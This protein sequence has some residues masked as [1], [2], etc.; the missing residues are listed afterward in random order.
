M[1]QDLVPAGATPPAPFIGPERRTDSSTR[2]FLFVIFK[3]RNLIIG[4]ALA[5]TGAALIA[6]LA[7]PP[8]RSAAAK[9]LIKGDRATLQISGL[10]SLTARVPHSP[11]ILQSEVELL[12]S[13][14]VLL[15]VARTLLERKAARTG[16]RFGAEDLENTIGA[17]RNN[18]LPSA[19]PDTNVIQ[20][21]YYDKTAEGAEASLK[22]IID[23][24][25]Q[26]HAMAYSGSNDL[27]TFYQREQEKAAADLQRAEEDLRRWQEANNVVAIEGQIQ[28]EI[29]HLA[30]LERN[31]HQV[32][33]DLEATRGRIANVEAQRAAQPE[34]AVMIREKVANPLIAKLKAD[35]AAAEVALKDLQ[36]NPVIEKLKGDVAAAEVAL[37]EPDKTPLV[38]KLRADVVAA[39][40]ALQELRQRYTDKDRR[41]Q[42]KLEQIAGIKKELA[43]AEKD[44]DT[45]ARERLAGLR[46][47]LA[48]AERDAETEARERISR[49]KREL[50]AAQAEAEI[51][52]RETMGPNPVREG[53]DRDL[54][55]ARAQLSAL[56]LQRDALRRQVRD[57][58]QT[59]AAL[60]DKKVAVDRLTRDVNVARD[61]YLLH[62]KRLNDSKLAAELDKQQLTDVALIERPYA[63]GE[64]DLLRRIA[65]VVLAGFVGLG[66]GA[67]AAF[68]LEFFNHSLRTSDDVEFHLGLPVL[69]VVPALPALRRAAA[70]PAWSGS[71][72]GAEQTPGSKKEA[73]S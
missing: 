3:W 59:L 32:E 51:P 50:A 55:T 73:T 60:R 8:V 1:Q 2:Q 20:I 61:T 10:Q 72:P 6:A 28:S 66:L 38:A 67:A 30:G 65:L 41:V 9:I 70:L 40:L 69:A 7:K 42:E 27:L 46:R 12:R 47:E 21:T 31:L 35:L 34:R 26:Q 24:Y 56:G 57:V 18:L 44:A 13:R 71:G 68:G 14:A 37:K 49:I 43:A 58:S 63:T 39:E 25:L 29:D 4:L 33:A 23:S 19:V 53:L 5:F 11:Q 16:E 36:R 48:A 45:T 62:T 64:T 52:S 17:L 54:A 15:P 22:L